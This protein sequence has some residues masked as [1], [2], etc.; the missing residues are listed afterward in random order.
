M[1]ACS[2][3]ISYSA[4]VSLSELLAKVSVDD[5]DDDVCFALPHCIQCNAV[6][7]QQQRL[8]APKKGSLSDESSLAAPGL[9]RP[10]PRVP[11]A[12]RTHRT[13]GTR[14]RGTHITQEAHSQHI[15]IVAAEDGERFG[16]GAQHVVPHQ[17]HAQGSGGGQ[18]RGHVMAWIEHA[19]TK[20]KCY[21]CIGL[22]LRYT[23]TRSM[24]T[25]IASCARTCSDI[26]M[27]A[28]HNTGA[29]P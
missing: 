3:I 10:G 12:R 7:V 29:P 19:G 14:T 5:D 11:H 17:R 6:Q 20:W 15:V 8:R 25:P 21:G 22:L 23:H 4:S 9:P 27:R 24:P 28:D 16:A 1:C 13:R 18:R 2:R 26:N